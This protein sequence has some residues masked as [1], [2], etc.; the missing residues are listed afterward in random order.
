MTEYEEKMFNNLSTLELGRWMNI[1]QDR[2]DLEEFIKVIKKRIDEMDDFIF[3][4]DYKTFK[5]VLP[6]KTQV[7][8]MNNK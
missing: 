1:K 2:P 8:I 3:S 7:W 4:D 6:F 5:R